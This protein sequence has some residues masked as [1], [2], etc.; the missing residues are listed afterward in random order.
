MLT[1]CSKRKWYYTI[2]KVVRISFI[3]YFLSHTRCLV[4]DIFIQ[5]CNLASNVNEGY[6]Y[7]IRALSKSTREPQSITTRWVSSTWRAWPLESTKTIKDIR[8]VLTVACRLHHHLRERPF[9]RGT[10]RGIIAKKCCY[11]L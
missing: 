11:Y 8:K 7:S 5:L 10:I 2:L 3:S 9:V 6:N 1:Q 4:R